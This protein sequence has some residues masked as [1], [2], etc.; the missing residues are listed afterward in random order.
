MPHS[1]SIG[2][3]EPQFRYVLDLSCHHVLTNTIDLCNDFFYDIQL[4][5]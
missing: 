1:A 4:N 5:H 2:T 3:I